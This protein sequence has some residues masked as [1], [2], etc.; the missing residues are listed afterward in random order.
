MLVSRALSTYV[1]EVRN[2]RAK[3]SATLISRMINPAINVGRHCNSEQVSTR[4][5]SV[6]G[7]YYACLTGFVGVWWH[8]M[9]GN[10]VQ[11][12]GKC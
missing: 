7:I 11:K 6:E 10:D 3:I 9:R 8:L 4:V 12:G 2:S 1:V 5:E